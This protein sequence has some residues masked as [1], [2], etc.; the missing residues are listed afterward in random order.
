MEKLLT[1][2]TKSLIGI[3]VLSLLLSAAVYFVSS[4]TD[5][6]CRVFLCFFILAVFLIT[7]MTIGT[8]VVWHILTNKRLANFKEELK[9]ELVEKFKEELEKRPTEDDKEYRDKLLVHE[10]KMA[11]I[12]YQHCCCPQRD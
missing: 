3:A 5:T 11:E 6:F 7:L 2:L 8:V 9:N 12:R 1:T 4:G 10:E